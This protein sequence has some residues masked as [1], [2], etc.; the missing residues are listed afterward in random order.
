M[1]RDIDDSRYSDVEK[2]AEDYSGSSKHPDCCMV[3]F[4][5]KLTQQMDVLLDTVRVV[6]LGVLRGEPSELFPEILLAVFQESGGDNY[7]KDRPG[8]DVKEFVKHRSLGSD[9]T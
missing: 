3:D 1:S 2:E 9:L 7:A 4:F 8:E 6:F 5:K